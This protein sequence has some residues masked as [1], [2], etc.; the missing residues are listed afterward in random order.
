MR[1]LDHWK[2][3]FGAVPVTLDCPH[4]RLN[5]CLGNAPPAFVG[6]GQINIKSS[7]AIEF[8]IFA[9]SPQ[10]E[11]FQRLLR[12]H[13]NPY[14]RL[15]QFNM[16]A[17]D[18][19][20]V[21][22]ACGETLPKVDSV[23]ENDALVTGEVRSLYAAVNSDQVSRESGV[24]LLFQPG[25][26]LPLETSMLTV[27][28]IGTEEIQRTYQMAKHT[29]TLMGATIE[30]F[31][32]SSGDALWI[33]ANA[34]EE[35]PH[36]CLE[37]WLSEPFRIL[38]GQLIYPRLVARNLGN[39][40]AHVSLRPSPPMLLKA[41]TSIGSLLS[42]EN[43]VTTA[44]FWE[45]Y[46][47]LLT[48][49][50][51][52]RNEQGFPDFESHRVTRFYEE[53]IQASQGSRWVWCLTLAGVAEGIAKLLMKPDERTTGYDEVEIEGLKRVIE[54]WKEGDKDLKQRVLGYVAHLNDKTIG[55][56]LH[57][58]V[59]RNLLDSQHEAAWKDM[60]NKVMHGNLVTPWST[61]DEDAKVIALAELVHNLTRELCGTG[62]RKQEGGT[63]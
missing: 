7:T 58:L 21:E 38:F 26:S 4:M 37:N 44:R 43:A 30:F 49:I 54:A 29:L 36:L 20:G 14:D 18:Y 24:E 25:F 16:F 32:E 15:N 57:E 10:V 50:A 17:T 35:M 8:K 59:E 45:L 39:G 60:R 12:A 61:E 13:S 42:S 46:K 19:E 31:R 55:K 27:H 62:I 63:S 1:T 47:A 3:R 52:A 6:P 48:M 9:S 28:S 51:T 22:W 11:A 2:T 34:S 5:T 40:S 53:I 41:S 33:T 23:S 56:F